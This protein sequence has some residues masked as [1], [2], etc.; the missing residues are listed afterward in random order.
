MIRANILAALWLLGSVVAA[1]AANFTVRIDGSE[2]TS[3]PKVTRVKAS[4]IGAPHTSAIIDS[5]AYVMPNG[6]RVMANDIDGIDFG[7]YFQWEDDD[8][9]DFEIDFPVRKMAKGRM[10]IYSKRET[11][12]IPLKK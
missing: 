2:A 11:I 1:S 12:R 10:E 9:I 8:I 7:R 3:N 4:L 6:N 5:I